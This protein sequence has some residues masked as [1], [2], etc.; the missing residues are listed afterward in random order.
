MA[1]IA[2]TVMVLYASILS[3][4]LPHAL[5]HLLVASIISAPAAIAIARI[6]IP[7]PEA[8]QTQAEF[9]ADM[10]SANSAME[11]ITNGTLD[12][13]KLLINII[14]MLVA[15]VELVNFGLASLPV[16][17]EHLLIVKSCR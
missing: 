4:V 13:V 2:G 10:I 6:M 11:A 1:T 12:G 17:G 16:G 14:A 3:P 9:T 15:L 7:V 8:E 5:G